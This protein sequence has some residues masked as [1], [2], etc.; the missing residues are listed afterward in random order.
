MAAVDRQAENLGVAFGKF[1]AETGH[2]TQLGRT[3]RGKCLWMRKQDSPIVAHPIMEGDGA[4]GRFRCEIGGCRANGEG[5]VH[6]PIC[7]EGRCPPSSYF[8]GCVA[9]GTSNVD[10]IDCVSLDLTCI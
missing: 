7:R 5:H 10:A 6:N 2:V 8:G 3:N 4:L 1:L 9:C